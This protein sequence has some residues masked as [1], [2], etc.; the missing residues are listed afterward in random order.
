MDPA[1]VSQIV[2]NEMTL[3]EENE[4]CLPSL[5]FDM[6]VVFKSYKSI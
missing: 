3:I 1:D 4:L 2:E 6:Q 5:H